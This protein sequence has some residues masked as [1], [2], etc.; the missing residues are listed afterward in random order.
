M[1]L[2]FYTLYMSITVTAKKYIASGSILVTE[3]RKTM[4]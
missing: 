1:A 3:R 4:Y 2:F